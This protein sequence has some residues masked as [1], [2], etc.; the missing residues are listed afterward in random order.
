MNITKL[1]Q[2]LNN[3]FITDY[4]KNI[5]DYL[6]TLTLHEVSCI[7]N[8]LL[9]LT[10]I[11]TGLIILSMF[12]GNYLIDYFKLEERFP[13]LARL[14]K[15]RMTLQKYSIM[16]NIFIFFFICFFGIFVNLLIFL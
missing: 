7:L 9:F 5:Y 4:I 15:L 2:H 1:L 10:L 16:W 13:K 3:N 12:Y 8:I 11:F 14:F 6:D